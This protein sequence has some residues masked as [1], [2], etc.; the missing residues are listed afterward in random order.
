MLRG[1]TRTLA[2]ADAVVLEASIVEEYKGSP[3]IHEVI[4]FMAERGFLLYDVC[5]VWRNTRGDRP[6]TFSATTLSQVSVPTK[7]RGYSSS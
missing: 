5:T 7:P 1:G 2:S 4:A 3:L 6:P